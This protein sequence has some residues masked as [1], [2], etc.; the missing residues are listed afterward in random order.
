MCD[1]EQTH[2][3]SLIFGRAGDAQRGLAMNDGLFNA[4]ACWWFRPKDG[5]AEKERMIGE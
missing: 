1:G 2:S 4:G 5:K 3:A